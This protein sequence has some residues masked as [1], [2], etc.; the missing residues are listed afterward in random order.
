MTDKVAPL[1]TLSRTHRLLALH[2]AQNKQKEAAQSIWH[3][4]P[5][6]FCPLKADIAWINAVTAPAFL[7]QSLFAQKSKVLGDTFDLDKSPSCPLGINVSS[8][9]RKHSESQKKTQESFLKTTEGQLYHALTQ[10]AQDPLVHLYQHPFHMLP[11]IDTPKRASPTKALPQTAHKSAQHITPLLMST[12]TSAFNWGVLGFLG[13][14]VS[15]E[16]MRAVLAGKS[17]LYEIPPVLGICLKGTPSPFLSGVEIALFVLDWLAQRNIP[18]KALEF[19]GPSTALLTPYTR[20]EVNRFLAYMEASS[21]VWP[22]DQQTL[23]FFSPPFVASTFQKDLQ[24]QALE[25]GLWHDTQQ[26][27][28]DFAIYDDVL[29]INLDQLSIGRNLQNTPLEKTLHTPTPFFFSAPY[30]PPCGTFSKENT[31]AAQFH[32]APLGF[33]NESPDFIKAA[34]MVKNAVQKKLTLKT[35]ATFSLPAEDPSTDLFFKHFEK[36]FKALG[37]TQAAH[38]QSS[39]G[40]GVLTQ[41]Q[42]TFLLSSPFALASGLSGTLHK[43]GIPDI[44]PHLTL[45]DLWPKESE[46]KS[47]H[48]LLHKAFN[49]TLQ[50]KNPS[51]KTDHSHPLLRHTWSP[52]PLLDVPTSSITHA[53]F[54]PVLRDH[55][56]GTHLLSLDDSALLASDTKD[57]KTTTNDVHYLDNDLKEAFKPSA[58]ISFY[59]GNPTILRSV[60]RRALLKYVPTQAGALEQLFAQKAPF[61]LIGNAHYGRG[62]D[63]VWLASALRLLN[64]RAVI[65][66]SFTPLVHRALLFCDILPLH[67]CYPMSYEDLQL[68]GDEKLSLEGLSFDQTQSRTLTLEITSAQNTLHVVPMVFAPC[69]QWRPH[70]T[71]RLQKTK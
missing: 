25:L 35:P 6:T 54:V 61:F 18:F 20:L 22:M 8:L 50:Q 10:S 41:S 30:K 17:L 24:K 66:K 60:T 44:A 43:T 53:S 33:L 56:I 36:D 13:L 65:A 12:N 55:Q 9:L 28:H 62:I 51:F 4:E 42:E 16:E 1:K 38:Q 68:K 47:L 15:V 69:G 19:F 32:L 14:Q 29:V 58:P 40:S 67:W 71:Q 11:H 26:A 31:P 21:L 45:K 49:E 5:N 2:L 48:A 52:W 39:Q 23:A 57:Q 63:A 64:V 70:N 3:R 37:I 7:A 27:N 59:L 34:L 46:E